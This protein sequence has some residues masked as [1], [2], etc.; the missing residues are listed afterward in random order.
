VFSRLL[1][2]TIRGR[3]AAT[4]ALLAIVLVFGLG[5]VLTL[6]VRSRY[7]NRLASQLEAQARMVAALVASDLAAGAGN[8][9]IDHRIKELGTDIDERLVVVDTSGLVVADSATLPLLFPRPQNG[10]DSA[11]VIR[12]KFDGDLIV[13]VPVESQSGLTVFTAHSLDDVNKA[14]TRLQT[15]VLAVAIVTSLAMVVI[16]LLVAGRITGPLEQLRRHAVMVAAGELDSTVQPATTRELRDLGTAFNAMTRRTRDLVNE[17]ERSRTRLE[18]IFANLGDGVVVIDGSRSVVGINAA[19]ARILGARL[20]WAMSK[21]FVVVARDADLHALVTGAF[22]SEGTQTA[23]VQLPR[24]AKTAEA[25]AQAI[26]VGGE[27]ICI[28]VVRDV[29]ELRRLEAVRRD[30]VANVSHELRTPLASIRA[31]VETLE[32]GAIDDPD[33]SGDFLGRVVG[34]VD[35]LSTLVD[36]L[37]NLARLESGQVDLNLES[38]APSVLITTGVERLRPQVERTHL[39]LIIEVADDLPAVNVDRARIEQ[40][41]LNLVH[42]GIKFTNPGGIIR[43]TATADESDLI[44]TVSDTGVGIAPDELERVFERFFKSDKARRSDGTGLGLAIAKHIVQSH[45]GSISAQS[46]PGVGS[47]FTFTLPL[48]EIE[49]TPGESALMA[50]VTAGGAD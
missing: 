29:T 35:R 18:A 19:A 28:V 37:L 7:E 12:F 36:D 31:L 32:A 47:S 45:G 1:P 41:L 25:V 50:S 5:L 3:L 26:E 2:S 16:A 33:V 11:K 38:V 30:F 43:V 13:A 22:R 4:S 24:T 20:Q 6:S 14:V 44:V 46:T 27:T 15:A 42:N 21:P 48:A 34:E 23:T 49:A 40:V 9:S 39:T 10:D 17:S 8:D